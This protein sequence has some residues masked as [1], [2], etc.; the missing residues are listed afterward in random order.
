MKIKDIKG[1]PNNPRKMSES[2]L[3]DLSHSIEKY[4]DLSGFLYNRRTK[5]LFG[6]HQKQKVV[7]KDSK[8]VIEHKYEK[9]TSTYTV[10]EGYVLIGDNKFKYR[11]VDAPEKWETEAMVAANKHSGEWDFEVLKFNFERF[12]DLD[13]RGM[14]YS[15]DELKAMNI[16]V[17]LSNIETDEAYVRNTPE[18]Y[19]QIDTANPNQNVNFGDVDERQT[20]AGKRFVIIIDCPD[21][22]TKDRLKETLLPEIA[23]VGCKVF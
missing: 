2:A 22:E 5:R 17:D 11:E 20:I 12:E 19:E 9:P 3:A 23:M 1:N 7:P 14:G 4:G 13:F 8:I 18:T 6:G 21:Q 10:A 16:D 15:V